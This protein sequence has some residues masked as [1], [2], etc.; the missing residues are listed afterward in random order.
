LSVWWTLH[1]KIK[2]EVEGDVTI[3]EAGGGGSTNPWSYV[4][5]DDVLYPVNVDDIWT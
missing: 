5:E 3:L 1:R 4:D 2:K